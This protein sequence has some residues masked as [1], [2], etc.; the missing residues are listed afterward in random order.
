MLSP[1]S[2]QI[3]ALLRRRAV[4]FNQN[5]EDIQRQRGSA[6]RG[7]IRPRRSGVREYCNTLWANLMGFFTPKE[8][9]VQIGR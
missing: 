6:Y 1:E 4:L 9:S 7:G 3:L 2:E 8:V 5:L